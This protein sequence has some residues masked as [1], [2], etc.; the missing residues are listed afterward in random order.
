MATENLAA[1]ADGNFAGEGRALKP[2]QVAE[3]A[4]DW[5][6]APAWAHYH[7]F[8]IDGRGGYHELEPYVKK[9]ISCWRS[10]GYNGPSTYTM[11]AG[12]DW[13]Q[14]LVERPKVEQ[15]A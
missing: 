13:R 4:I 7:A 5:S 9:R 12:V 14:S 11:P 2:E 15:G 6:Q 10:D 1:P 3:M 8:D